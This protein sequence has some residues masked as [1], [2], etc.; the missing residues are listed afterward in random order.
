[1]AASS[2]RTWLYASCPW[3]SYMQVVQYSPTTKLGADAST[4]SCGRQ[5]QLWTT[6]A[7][8][9]LNFARCCQ[10]VQLM[11]S[12]LLS[13]PYL[14]PM[15]CVALAEVQAQALEPHLLPQPAQPLLKVC[16]HPLL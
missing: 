9:R 2:K 5:I 13:M 16:P 4:Y 6:E 11:S 3:S 7:V 15:P 10:P 8:Q 1:M 12:Q 14:D